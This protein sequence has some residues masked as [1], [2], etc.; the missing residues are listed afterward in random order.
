MVQEATASTQHSHQGQGIGS[1]GQ[2]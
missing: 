2:G 1:T